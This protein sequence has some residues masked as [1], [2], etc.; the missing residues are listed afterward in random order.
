MARLLGL[1]YGTE[2][3][4]VAISDERGRYAFPR[5]TLNARDEGAAL[6][7]LRAI[8]KEEDI[9]RIVVGIPVALAPHRGQPAKKSEIRAQ[10]EAFA[11]RL[12]AALAIPVETEDERMTTRL[13]DVLLRDTQ[14]RAQA[15]KATRDQLAAAL[16]LQTYLDRTSQP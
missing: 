8:C 11:G 13:A 9:T 7:A 12:H 3:I 14:K 16:L 4:G 15:K 5:V 1:D 2:R 10:A 6:A